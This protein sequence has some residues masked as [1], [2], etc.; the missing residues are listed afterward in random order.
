MPLGIYKR[1][2]TDRPRPLR[3]FAVMGVAVSALLSGWRAAQPG[4]GSVE[5]QGV[6]MSVVK[7]GIG[8]GAVAGGDVSER[9]F[10]HL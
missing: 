7:G 8:V 10:G 5:A 4:P 1:A 3:C 6:G 2:R 9:P